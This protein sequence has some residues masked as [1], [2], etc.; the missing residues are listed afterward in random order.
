MFNVYNVKYIFRWNF[1]LFIFFSH[2]SVVPY[3]LSLKINIQ[4]ILLAFS[5]VDWYETNVAYEGVLFVI[6]DFAA[7]RKTDQKVSKCQ[8]PEVEITSVKNPLLLFPF[9]LPFLFP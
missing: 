7:N 1:Y 8:T 3:G 9:C 2:E 6:I 4:L 5:S